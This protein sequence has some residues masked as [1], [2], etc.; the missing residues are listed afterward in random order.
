MRTIVE[1]NAVKI[2]DDKEN[3]ELLYFN[4]GRELGNAV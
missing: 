4:V 2:V 1:C 3:P